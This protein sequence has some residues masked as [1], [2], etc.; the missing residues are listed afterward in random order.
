MFVAVPVPAPSVPLAAES[1]SARGPRRPRR[2]LRGGGP[3]H[4]PRKGQL[5]PPH[6]TRWD[7]SCFLLLTINYYDRGRAGRINFYF[8]CI[9]YILMFH[10]LY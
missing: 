7:N 1:R 9:F 4:A 5:D 10:G 8:F 3:R 2:R 6:S